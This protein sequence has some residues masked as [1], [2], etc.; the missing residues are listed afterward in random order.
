M[1]WQPYDPSLEEA[2]SCAVLGALN[3]SHAADESKPLANA[4]GRHP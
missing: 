1:D 3:V 2:A 4:K